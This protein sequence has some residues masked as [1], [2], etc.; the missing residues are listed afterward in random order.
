MGPVGA[1]AGDPQ[2]N[3]HYMELNKQDVAK[4][5]QECN[6]AVCAW[7]EC[8]KIMHYDLRTRLLSSLPSAVVQ[9]LSQSPH[10][11]AQGELQPLSQRSIISPPPPPSILASRASYP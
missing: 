4:R 11:H 6:S 3:A 7:I 5:A 8:E 2:A 10:Q 1:L 9:L